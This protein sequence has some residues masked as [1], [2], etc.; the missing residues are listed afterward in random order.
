MRLITNLQKEIDAFDK[1]MERVF[2]KETT[3]SMR[4]YLREKYKNFR[5]QDEEQEDLEVAHQEELQRA[6]EAMEARG[7]V[8]TA[9]LLRKRSGPLQ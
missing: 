1:D 8:G 4:Q 3:E 7:Y 6:I 2:G 5:T 9:F